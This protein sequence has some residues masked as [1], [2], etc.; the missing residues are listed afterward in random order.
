[1]TGYRDLSGNAR[2]AGRFHPAPP[3]GFARRLLA[4]AIVAAAVAA[5]WYLRDLVLLVFAAILFAIALRAL[6][7]A[8]TRATG[9]NDGLSFLVAAAAIAAGIGL[10]I[11][12]LGAQLQAQLMQLGDQLPELLSPLEAWLG[13]GNM[14][15]W[16]AERAE[17]IINETTLMS[18]IAGLSGTAATVLVNVVLVV[19]AGFYI[20]YR[21]GLYLNGFLLLFPPHL[22]GR[23]EETLGA[24]DA[25]LRRWLAGQ[26]AAML[27]VGALT[28]LGLWLLGM[29]SALALGFIAGILEFVPFLGPVLAAAPALALALAVDPVMALWVLALYVVIQQVEGNLLNPLIQQHAVSLPPAVTLFALLAFGILFGP[30][31]VFLATPLAVVCLVTVK[32]LW[33]HDALGEAI[34]LPGDGGEADE[35]EEA[36]PADRD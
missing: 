22:R 34:S 1:M 19:V 8:V 4:V 16:L 18:R 26:V 36:T 21:P 25:A 13:V 6:A 27:V 20:G 23:T 35:A 31:G 2:V 5:L 24:L 11:A 32:Q 3:A 12:V 10:F 15:D 30:L 14:G 17:A 33:V 7:S 9:V 28:F 29:E